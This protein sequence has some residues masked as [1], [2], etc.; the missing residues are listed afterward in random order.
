VVTVINVPREYLY[1]FLRRNANL[2]APGAS[3]VVVNGEIQE[4]VCGNQ[5]TIDE[6]P[7]GCRFVNKTVPLKHIFTGSVE[8]SIIRINDSMCI[9]V[10]EGW[11]EGEDGV[12]PRT[13][14]IAG[15]VM[16]TPLDYYVKIRAELAW[17]WSKWTK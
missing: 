16:F 5:V 10:R 6:D 9:L 4:L 12:L 3:G 14:E 1:D 11:Y 7:S 8:A 2:V 17:N 15:P 13:N